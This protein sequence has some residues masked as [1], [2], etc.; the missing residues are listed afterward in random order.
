MSEK[1]S[2]GKLG[3]AE[4]RREKEKREEKML[5]KTAYLL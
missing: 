4:I 2:N 1:S 5:T 3:N